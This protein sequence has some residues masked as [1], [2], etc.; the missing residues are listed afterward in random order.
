MQRVG[1]RMLCRGWSIRPDA[2]AGQLGEAA[3]RRSQYETASTALACQA[4]RCTGWQK[5]MHLAT[6]RT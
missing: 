1:H 2:A 4:G 5:R 3:V 6:H